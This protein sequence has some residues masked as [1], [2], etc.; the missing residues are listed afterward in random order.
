MK[1]YKITLEKIIQK[2]KNECYKTK[3]NESKYNDGYL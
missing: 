2:T 1:N 3:I